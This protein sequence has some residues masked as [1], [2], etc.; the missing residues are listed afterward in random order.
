MNRHNLL[1]LVLLE[2]VCAPLNAEEILSLPQAIQMA[3]QYRSEIQSAKLSSERAEL[4]LSLTES[5]LGWQANASAGWKNSLDLFGQ[6]TAQESLSAGMV[7]QQRNGNEISLQTSYQKDHSDATGVSLF[8]NPV[9]S[10][11]MSLDYRIPLQKGSDNLAYGYAEAQSK[12]SIAIS[13]AQQRAS[14]ERIG[15]QVISI[16]H[17]LLDLQIQRLELQHAIERTRKLEE[18]IQENSRLGMA[19]KRDRLSVQARMAA[20]HADEMLLQR[21][22]RTQFLELERMVGNIRDTVKVKDYDNIVGLPSTLTAV[23]RQV[24]SRDAVIASN[25]AK[26]SAA[27]SLLQLNRDKQKDQLDL[28]VS[29]G[30]ETRRGQNTSGVL[31]RNEWVGGLRLEYQLPLDRR[32]ADARTR[33]D[34]IELDKIRLDNRG[35][36]ADL[37][38]LLKQWFQEWRITTATIKQYRHRKSIED[39]RY[40]EVKSRYL[41]GRTDIREMLDA[42]ESLSTAEKLLA[43]EEARRS[44]VL[45]LLSNRIGRFAV[46]P[47]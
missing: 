25:N 46:N 3:L 32:G 12:M 36:E 30:N 19:E 6:P 5:Q 31:D 33:Q 24:M 8:P 1:L 14:A 37:K 34:L 26:F 21:E 27:E 28:V 44:L 18:F 40:K 11:G 15:E 9:E 22:W 38:N 16:Y 17:H 35:Y 29:V 4:G 41:Q 20:Q 2:I 39:L 10:Y 43:R 45:A 7:K 42:E 13:A 23:I 47:E